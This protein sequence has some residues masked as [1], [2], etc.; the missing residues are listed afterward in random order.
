VSPSFSP[1]ILKQIKK[2]L[3]PDM[4]R[5]SIEL[6]RRHH[7]EVVG[8]FMLGFPGE[9]R[10]DMRR[11]IDLAMELPLTGAS[12]SIYCPLPGAEDYETTFRE[13][14]PDHDVLDSFDFV[15]YENNLSE[16][17]ADELRA[18]QRR[19]YLRFHLRPPVL[20]HMLR[21]LNSLEKMFFIARQAWHQVFE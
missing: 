15:R 2:N 7:I 3:S 1:R 5:S 14:R 8:F 13:G 10:E 20:R 6:L 21:N 17:P 18:L 9:T 4:V 16:V 12:F 11:T 19:T